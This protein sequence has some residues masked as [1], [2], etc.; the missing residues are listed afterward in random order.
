MTDRKICIV[1]SSLTNDKGSGIERE[2][3][4]LGRG[5]SRR[6]VDTCICALQTSTASEHLFNSLGI[7]VFSLSH[8]ENGNT[9]TPWVL[10]RFNS[11]GK[12]L[13]GYLDKQEKADWYIVVADEAISFRRYLHDG[14]C[15]I[16]SNGSWPLL[17]L[18][19]TFHHKHP[20]SSKILS[21]DMASILRLEATSASMYSKRFANSNFTRSLMSF[22]YD[23]SYDGVIYP[24][25]D[26]SVFYKTER[27]D[28]EGY[29][30][31]VG[32]SGIAGRE[33]N[34]R[35]LE[36]IAKN[37]RMK[38]VGGIQ[39]K[40]AENVGFVS[41]DN[42]RE[43]YSNASFTILPSQKEYFGYTVAES[44]ACGT[45]AMVLNVGG[46]SEQVQDG[47]NGWVLS[48]VQQLF[49]KAISVYKE[50]YSSKMRTNAEK[51]AL[52]FE[53]GN[54]VDTLLT[55]LSGQASK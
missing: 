42:L 31:V 51:S 24:P 53:T 13:A 30:L 21:L 3:S 50:G 49:K 41:D 2:V 48:N 29:L 10:T 17:Y 39:I 18:D 1:T 33:S 14:N 54:V 6:G 38:A 15:A 4:N 45:P 40:G 12:K 34:R 23:V 52:K 35:I 5:L 28:D 26:K 20:L 36:E 47:F 37:A 8:S 19:R 7:E 27:T 55:Q 9:I 44:L 43:I 11:I 46:P 25:V 16:I 22:I 32:R